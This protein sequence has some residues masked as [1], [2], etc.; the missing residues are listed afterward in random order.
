[1]KS[2]DLWSDDVRS[3]SAEFARGL[4]N[5]DKK[6]EDRER[7]RSYRKSEEAR[8]SLKSAAP[9]SRTSRESASSRTEEA[10]I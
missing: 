1:M 10:T 3:A 4:F 6:I 9:D 8:S 5:H 7:E 2:N